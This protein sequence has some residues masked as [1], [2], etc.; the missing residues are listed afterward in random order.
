MSIP[1]ITSFLEGLPT[2]GE[3]HVHIEHLTYIDHAALVA[4]GDWEKRERA[5]GRKV[6]LEWEVVDDR[7]ERVVAK[8]ARP[9]TEPLGGPIGSAG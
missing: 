8:A 7:S 1:K 5:G 9:P 4:I 3:A 2:E 6:V